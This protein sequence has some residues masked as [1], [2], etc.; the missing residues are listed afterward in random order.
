L[1][2][3]TIKGSKVNLLYSTYAIEDSKSRNFTERKRE[4]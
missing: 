3:P 2:K 4:A 1:L